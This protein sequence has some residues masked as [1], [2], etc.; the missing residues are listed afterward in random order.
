MANN[1]QRI[2]IETI[3]EVDFENRNRATVFFRGILTAPLIVFIWSLG[4]F[5]ESYIAPLLAAPVVLALVVRH[6]YPSYLLTFNHAML[7]IQT[8]VGTY[9][10]CLTDEYPTIERN[11]RV[12]VLF[13]ELEGGKKLNRWLPLVKW[14]LAIPLIIVGAIYLLIALVV[15]VIAWVITWST[16]RYPEWAAE[17]VLGTFK[18]INRV[19][20]YAFVLVS[21]E[22]PSFS[23]K[24]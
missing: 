15:S 13:P 2:Q 6:V 5:S 17:N 23:L 8:R 12:A 20:G 22:Y 9:L 14:F 21:D 7:E 3:I 10:F 4:S 11:P 1:T 19:Y 18:Y 16:G 24:A